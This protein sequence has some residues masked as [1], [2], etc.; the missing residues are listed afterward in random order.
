[1]CDWI[2]VL[3]IQLTPPWKGVKGEETGEQGPGTIAVIAVEMGGLE[4]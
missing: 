3:N 1:M 4:P 2:F